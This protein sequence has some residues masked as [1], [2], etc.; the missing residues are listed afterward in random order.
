MP[1]S[2]SVGGG[3]DLE[4]LRHNKYYQ[5]LGTGAQDKIKIFDQPEART[6]LAPL[7]SLESELPRNTEGLYDEDPEVQQRQ[8]EI[9]LINRQREAELAQQTRALEELGRQREAEIAERQR[10]L[11]LIKRSLLEKGRLIQQLSPTLHRKDYS[12]PL[13]QQRAR[14]QLGVRDERAEFALE[15]A[16]SRTA[17]TPQSAQNRPVANTRSL[18]YLAHDDSVQQLPLH[19]PGSEEPAEQF[20]EQEVSAL[21]RYRSLPMFEKQQRIRDYERRARAQPYDLGG[22]DAE[23]GS[24]LFDPEANA[25]ALAR[26]LRTPLSGGGRLEVPDERYSLERVIG[27]N[28]PAEQEDYRR[29]YHYRKYLSKVK[30]LQRLQAEFGSFQ[31]GQEA[32]RQRLLHLTQSL[33]QSREQSPQGPTQRATVRAPAEQPNIAERRSKLSSNI[34]LGKQRILEASIALEQLKRN[35]HAQQRRQQQQPQQTPKQPQRA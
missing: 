16:L 13:T 3:Q 22:L 6:G 10:E 20:A 21:R 9:A 12:A 32:K 25:H 27:Q 24:D 18:H 29:D 19:A 4:S 8:R 33:A 1:R 26:D 15:H 11:E 7:E 35:Q 34:E 17:L 30:S 28:S 5:F 14:P 23:D 2:P 31:E